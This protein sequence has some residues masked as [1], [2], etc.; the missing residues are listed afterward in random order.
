[1]KLYELLLN[2]F[3]GEAIVN[4]FQARVFRIRMRSMER[5]ADLALIQSKKARAQARAAGALTERCCGCCR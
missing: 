2:S 4:D 5:A 3:L 1:M